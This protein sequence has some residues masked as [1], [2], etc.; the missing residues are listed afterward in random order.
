MIT[1]HWLYALAGAMFAAIALLSALDRAN[2]KRFGNAAFWG[3]MALSL[4][5][6]DLIGDFGNGLLVLGLAGLAGFDRNGRR[7]GFRVR[8]RIIDKHVR[9]DF[10]APRAVR[11]MRRVTLPR[12]VGQRVF[13]E[14]GDLVG[15]QMRSRRAVI[16]ARFSQNR[17]YFLVEF[18]IHLNFLPPGTQRKT[19]LFMTFKISVRSV[20]S[21]A[22]F[23]S[24]FKERFTAKLLA[25]ARK[26]PKPRP[27]SRD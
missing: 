7:S 13:G 19:N 25:P 23:P 22:K 27:I 26:L 9:K 5:A 17:I 14:R 11:E 8:F 2:P 18:K 4:L 6:G 15:V 1:L 3:L 10:A 12:N 20:S 24:R 21:A 16:A